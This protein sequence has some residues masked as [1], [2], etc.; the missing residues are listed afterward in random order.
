[1]PISKS[2]EEAYNPLTW[3]PT[4]KFL[5]YAIWGI[6]VS[7]VTVCLAMYFLVP[8]LKDRALWPAPMAVVGLVGWILMRRGKMQVAI[9]SLAAGTWVCVAVLVYVGGGI[10]APVQFVFPLVIF[11]LGWLTSTRA[12]FLGAG[13]TAVFTVAM[14][15]LEARG[16]LPTA[17][18][19]PPSLLGLVQI[20]VFFMASIVV[21]V[22]VK[23]YARRLEDLRSINTHY[24]QR[25]SDLEHTKQEL[26]QAQAVAKVGSWVYAIE[27]DTL[28]P[29]NET[30]RILG[31][32][33]GS[34]LDME[35]YLKRTHPDD[36]NVVQATIAEVLKNRTSLDAEHRIR[37]GNTTTWVRQKAEFAPEQDRP[38]THVLGI[39]QDI[40]ERKL[41]ELSLQQSEKKFSTAFQ[42]S[43]VAASIATLS[44]GRFLEANDKYARD[45]GWNRVEL[46]NRTTHDINLW[47]NPDV[48]AQWVEALKAR[49]SVVDYETVWVHRNGN[50]RSVSI[51]GEI[52]EYD[53]KPCILAYITD[54]TERKAAEA[55]IQNLAFFD[56]LTGLPNR[57]LLMN[58]LELALAATQRHLR[59]GGLL[60]IDIDKFKTLNDAH[61]HN[62]G[63][64]LLQQ[65]ALRLGECVREGDTVA[66]LGGDEFVVMLDSLSEDALIAASQAEAVAEKIRA[67]L[68][69]NYHIDEVL[70]HS[71]ASIGVT[72]F[73]ERSE[74]LDEPL[75]RADTAMYQAKA[76]GR[77][78]IRFFDPQMQEAISALIQ[79][80]MELRNAVTEKSFLLLYQPQIN[81]TGSV[82]GGEVL[83][84]WRHPLR[85][86]VSPI[87]F[88]RVAETSD[89]IL[90][91]GAWIL[92]E[93]CMQL[94]RWANQPGF[95]HLT[96]AVNVSARQFQQPDFVQLVLTVLAR[97]GANPMRLKLEITES[98]LIDDIESII[99]KMTTLKAQG[100]AFS[101]D[102][103]GTGYSSLSYLK[104]LP[105]D[106]LKIDRSFVHDVLTDPNDAAIARM[107]IVLAETLGLE[108]I[109]EGVETA[110]QQTLLTSQG[111]Q[112]FQGFYISRPVTDTQFEAFVRERN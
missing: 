76:A 79:L 47:P 18:Y 109:A 84:R 102:D 104:Q 65:I 42:S 25:T 41:A 98:M 54:I 1:M 61:G 100:V 78:A 24:V 13:V 95:A 57:R 85:G 72:L 7:V 62:K 39:T 10:T 86:L 28:F 35:G 36:R 53:H 74:G 73:G 34:T 19:S 58:R 63:D 103:F 44:D 29:S 14:V 107:V 106:Q 50:Q 99:E 49:G 8:T 66:R 105:L 30:C 81:A 3:E 89:L 31:L 82:T 91:L 38:G 70:F 51:S 45:F 52:I 56:A 93:A 60:F 94:T 64:L 87:E 77:N 75:T 48:R 97:T 37:Y 67:A 21:Y 15:V 11:M 55:Q 16:A 112:N 101:L 46:L 59:L 71:T 26:H 9:T 20:F 110:A 6:L 83:V 90:P 108:V 23:A 32:P 5:S 69:Q 22:L 2:K 12:A 40:N 4:P 68:D 43:P 88:I 33:N 80:E 111:C 17:P 92:E 96:L 27:T